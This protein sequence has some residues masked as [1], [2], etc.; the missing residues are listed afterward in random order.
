MVESEPIRPAHWQ[1]CY[2]R[3]PT[4]L[5]HSL[6]DERAVVV[7]SLGPSLQGSRQDRGQP[8][9]LL[10]VDIAGRGSVVVVTRRFCTINTR[11]P[12]NHVEIDLQNA[13]LAEDEFGHGYQ[14]ELRSLAEDGAACS[15]KYILYEL[16]RYS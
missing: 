4:H 13:P 15:E 5:A 14:R 3:L 10:P 7:H 11:A 1:G 8:C 2:S 6:K 9:C 12:F 16:L